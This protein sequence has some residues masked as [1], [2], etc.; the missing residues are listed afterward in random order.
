MALGDH[1]ELLRAACFS[2]LDRLRSRFGDEL[3]RKHALDE[4][5][6]FD[7]ARVPFLNWQKGIFRAA[8]QTGA[9]A[10]SVMTSASSPYSADGVSDDDG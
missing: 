1:D 6:R 4:G 2:A 5:F 9:A 3:P 10:L 8:R 7:G